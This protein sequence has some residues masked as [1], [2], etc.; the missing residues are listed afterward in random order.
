MTL[1]AMGGNMNLSS[2]DMLLVNA[3][4]IHADVSNVSVHAAA[5]LIGDAATNKT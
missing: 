2:G 1:E 5:I 3:G 4:R